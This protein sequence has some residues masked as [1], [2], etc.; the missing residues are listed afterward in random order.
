MYPFTFSFLTENDFFFFLL[1]CMI[2]G[3]GENNDLNLTFLIVLHLDKLNSY[4]K[5]SVFLMC[6]SLLL[7]TS[8]ADRKEEGNP[9]F[10]EYFFFLRGGGGRWDQIHD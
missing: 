1:Y 3:R 2:H 9:D 10:W 7:P 8:G 4:L 6:F 5:M